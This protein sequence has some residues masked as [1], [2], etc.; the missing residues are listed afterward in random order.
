MTKNTEIGPVRQSERIASLDV[1]RGFALL[2][3]LVMNIQSFAMVAVAYR[4]PTVYGD[5]SGANFLVWAGSHLLADQKFMTLF[6]LLFGAGVVLFTER[7]EARNG[8]VAAVHY[9]RTLWLLLFGAAHAYLLWHGDVLFTY[10]ICA[11]FVFLLRKRS[12]RFLLVLGLIFVAVP[13]FVNAFFNW[14]LAFAPPESVVEIRENWQPSAAVV[15]EEVATY[16]DSWLEQM[17]HRV[18]ESIMMQTFVFA[19]LLGWRAAG[20][21]LIGMSLFKLGVLSARRSPRFYGAMMVLGFGI[22][23][24]LIGYGITRS[25]GANWAFPYAQFGS[26]QYNYWGSLFV[27]GGYIGLVMTVCQRGWLSGLTARLAAVGRMALTNY[28]AHTIICTFIFYGHGLGL[29][30]QVS[31]LGQL[32]IVLAIWIVQLWVSPIWLRHYRFGP[33]EWLWRSLTYWQRQTLRRQTSG[34]VA[35]PA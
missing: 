32:G 33:F 11:L 23:L 4:N 7:L 13:S 3:I 30:G 6:A 26:V 9:R 24:P 35:S 15:A 1:L 14:S 25:F 27:S 28:L 12:P 17:A 31:R 16:Q 5:L 18:P 20:L 10:A 22:G 8:R 29:F 34:R 19:T 2:G 21:M